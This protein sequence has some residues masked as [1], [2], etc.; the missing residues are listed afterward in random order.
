M[1]F[2]AV[3]SDPAAAAPIAAPEAPEGADLLVKAA[4]HDAGFWDAHPEVDRYKVTMHAGE[5]DL[6]EWTV[7][8]WLKPDS[9]QGPAR[10][11]A[12]ADI[13]TRPA[14]AAFVVHAAHDLEVFG[15]HPGLAAWR[16][17]LQL[18]EDG[19]GAAHKVQVWMAPPAAA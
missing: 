16:V 19:P 15:R 5:A 9:G 3:S 14:D 4:P 8:V 1:T 13:P 6:T 18:N 7:L 10:I 12:N 11:A 2:E 17:D